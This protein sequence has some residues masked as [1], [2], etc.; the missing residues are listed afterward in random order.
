MFHP[1]EN[2]DLSQAIDELYE[3]S[4]PLWGRWIGDSSHTRW[5]T[6][7]FMNKGFRQFSF[8]GK[9]RSNEKL[10]FGMYKNNYSFNEI[11]LKDKSY[12]EWLLKVS[13]GFCLHENDMNLLIEN[14]RPIK[15]ISTDALY[16]NKIK[17]IF[18]DE[19]ESNYE[20]DIE[21]IRRDEDEQRLLDKWDRDA[22]GDHFRDDPE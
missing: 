11:L 21:G 9:Y 10:E 15:G 22:F 19:Q 4:N 18:L 14:S 7:D 8:Y 2:L 6:I 12:N 13:H 1:D 3:Q 20:I 17:N 16:R 5:G